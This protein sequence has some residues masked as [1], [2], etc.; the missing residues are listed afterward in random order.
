MKAKVAAK[1]TTTK[2]PPPKATVSTMVLK[3]QVQAIHIWHHHSGT[4]YQQPLIWQQ[5]HI[6]GD[7]LT[8]YE[9]F[10]LK[11]NRLR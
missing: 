9:A 8:S 1:S 6:M 7:R 5:I 2:I 3:S 10:E 4:Y 11:I